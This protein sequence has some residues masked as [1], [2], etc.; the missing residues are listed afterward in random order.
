MK[1]FVALKTSPGVVKLQRGLIQF[2]N[3]T[4]PN[5]HEIWALDGFQ[6]GDKTAT[7]VHKTTAKYG[8]YFAY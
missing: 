5:V 3:T 1:S 8:T 7:L 2:A 6:S 4:V